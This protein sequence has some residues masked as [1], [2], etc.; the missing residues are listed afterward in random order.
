M[1]KCLGVSLFD[2]HEQKTRRKREWYLDEP[3][4]IENIDIQQRESHIIT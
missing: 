3:G 4:L 2:G 1:S